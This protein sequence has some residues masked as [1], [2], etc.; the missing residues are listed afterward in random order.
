MPKRKFDPDDV[1]HFLYKIGDITEIAIRFIDSINEME[2]NQLR[3]VLEM[4]RYYNDRA[5]AMLEGDE[6]GDAA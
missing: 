3:T 1:L 4:Q 6:E 2:T 5:Q